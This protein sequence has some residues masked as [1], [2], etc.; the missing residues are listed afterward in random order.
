MKTLVTWSVC[1]L[2]C[3]VMA[4]AHDA[5]A[6]DASKPL[7]GATRDKPFVNSLGMKFVPV[8]GT[9]V[10]FSIWD[11]R[12]RD[13]RAYVEANPRVLAAWHNFPL[14]EFKQGE[15]H[16]V[17]SMSWDDAKAF[18]AW[19]TQKERKEGKIG[20]DQEYRL[21]TDSEWSV[22]VGPGKYPWGNNWPPPKGAGNYDPSFK[23]DDY[24]NTSPVGS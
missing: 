2:L 6:P 1:F 19:L 8:P 17:A 11:T 7:A 13:Y 23:V 15:D 12:V 18:C 16:P 4:L 20:Q 24:V 22:A 5:G 14:R 9:K 10:L 3:G 21:P